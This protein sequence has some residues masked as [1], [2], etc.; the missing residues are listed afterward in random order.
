MSAELLYQVEMWDDRT[1]R[2]HV[3][4]LNLGEVPVTLPKVEAE[5]VEQTIRG[6]MSDAKTRLVEAPRG[7]TKHP[8]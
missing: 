2:W 1:R 7:S 5:Q 6:H 8:K 3:V 4:Q